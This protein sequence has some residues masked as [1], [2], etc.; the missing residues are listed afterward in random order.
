MELNTLPL[1]AAAIARIE[2]GII[3]Y[4]RVARVHITVDTLH[5]GTLWVTATQTEPVA[6][7]QALTAGEIS[8][9]VHEVFALAAQEG[10]TIVVCPV[11]LVGMGRQFATIPHG[12][13]ELILRRMSP[14]MLIRSTPDGLQLHAAEDDVPADIVAGVLRR[15]LAWRNRGVYRDA[16]A[17][18]AD[19]DARVARL[20]A[21][22][23]QLD[24][25]LQQLATDMGYTDPVSKL[26]SSGRITRAGSRTEGAV[27]YYAEGRVQLVVHYTGTDI[28]RIERVTE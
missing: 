24:A 15:A 8:E 28:T 13:D 17:T 18:R 14:R 22:R 4:R 10:L 1:S 26:M 20:Q 9:R 6:D 21:D 5:N 25:A 23:E 7:H 11:P 27:R 12:G 3:G 16:A 2:N 19:L